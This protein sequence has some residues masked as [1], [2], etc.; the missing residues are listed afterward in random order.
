[1]EGSDAVGGYG[2]GNLNLE[3]KKREMKRGLMLEYR[4]SFGVY[5]GYNFKFLKISGDRAKNSGPTGKWGISEILECISG[6]ILNLGHQNH[7]QN[8][9]VQIWN[10]QQ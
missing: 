1:M 3:G 7:I 4:V 5:L 8:F 9:E 2:G 6:D 10:Q